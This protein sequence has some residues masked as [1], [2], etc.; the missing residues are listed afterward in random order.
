[1]RY[2]YWAILRRFTM[3]FRREQNLSLSGGVLWSP[4]GRGEAWSPPAG[5][6]SF[7]MA[8]T[9]CIQSL[10]RAFVPCI[11]L[12]ALAFV[13]GCVRRGITGSQEAPSRLVQRL[14]SSPRHPSGRMPA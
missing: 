11:Q 3:L 5:P 12:P 4:A 8:Y 9:R 14:A 6:P 10:A 13:P 2:R 7:V 1:M